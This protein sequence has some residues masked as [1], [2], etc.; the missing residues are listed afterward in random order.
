VAE[1]LRARA[2][3]LRGVRAG[4]KVRIGARARVDRPWTV[5]IG[6]RTQLESDV[7]LKMVDDAAR[8]MVGAYAFIGRGSE[9]DVQQEVV[10]GPHSLI[11]PNVFITDHNHRITRGQRIDAQGCEAR[12][13]RIGDDVWIGT[14]AVV[15]P[16]VTIG[17][18][19]VVAAGA[20]VRDDVAPMQIVAGI[21][22][23]PVGER[24]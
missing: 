20:V 22:A 2:W 21:P 15:L 3:A 24:R 16:G 18:G 11:A 5:T 19:A 23:R 7:W 12:P 1:R 14:R 13:V 17:D 10:I 8:L 4:A 9:F 6:E